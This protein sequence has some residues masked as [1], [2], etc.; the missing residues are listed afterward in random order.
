MTNVTSFSY[1]ISEIYFL[2]N[3]EENAYYYWV[4]KV[5]LFILREREGEVGWTE[6]GERKSQAGS[7]LSAQSPRQGSISRT[8]RS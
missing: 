4:F 2:F 3:K 8:V 6:R 5:Y 1:G 7:M